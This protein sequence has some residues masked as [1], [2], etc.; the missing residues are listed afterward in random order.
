[1]GRQRYTTEQIIGKR[2]ETE[3]ELAKEHTV[4]QV[5]RVLRITEQTFYRWRTEYGGLK[6][7]QIRP[8]G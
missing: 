8:S 7:D 6:V 3:V 1:M 4:A 5:C 2:R